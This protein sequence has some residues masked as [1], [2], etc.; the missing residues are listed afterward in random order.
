MQK[1]WNLDLLEVYKLCQDTQSG[2]LL[3]K[4]D[5]CLRGVGRANYPSNHP[6]LHSGAVCRECFYA[7]HYDKA[8]WLD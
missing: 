1:S 2:G 3:I 7:R 5:N 4:Q 6:V 8:D